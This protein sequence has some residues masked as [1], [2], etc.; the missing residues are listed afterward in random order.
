VG[1]H[2]AVVAELVGVQALAVL[3]LDPASLGLLLQQA[4]EQAA[5][6]SRVCSTSRPLDAML[7]NSPA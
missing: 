1:Q 2:L 3:E 6:M 5:S 4:L 7:R